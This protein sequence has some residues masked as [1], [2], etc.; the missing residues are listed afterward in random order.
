MSQHKDAMCA[1]RRLKGGL[2]AATAIVS[3]LALAA[4]VAAAELQEIVVTAR[5]RQES[6]LNVPVITSAVTQAQIERQQV[7]DVRDVARLVPALQFGTAPTVNGTIV[8]LRGIGT[9]AIDPSVDQSISL[10]LD[11][12]TFSQGLSY[13]AVMFDVGQV[14]VLRGPQALFYGK[15]SPAGVISVRSADPGQQAEFIGRAGYEFEA[16]EQR[17][18]LIASGPLSDTVGVRLAGLYYNA[19]GFFKNKAIAIPGTGAIAPQ[20]DRDKRYGHVLRAT[21]LWE[22]TDRFAARLKM[23]TVKDRWYFAGIGQ[24]VSCPNGTIGTSVLITGQIYQNLGADD[25]KLDRISRVNSLDPAAFQGIFFNGEPQLRNQQ[26]FGTLNLDYRITPELTLTSLTGYLRARTKAVFNGGTSAAFGTT[27]D[28]QNR[29]NRKE[30]QQEFRLNSDYAGPFNFS[31]GLFYQDGEIFS[32]SNLLTN[33]ALAFGPASIFGPAGFR[34]P[35]VLTN[36]FN[37]ID[38]KTYSAFAQGRFKVTP[39]L[40]IAA[41]A[42]YTDEKRTVDAYNIFGGVRTPIRLAVTEL[43]AKNW[44]PELTVSYKPVDTVT[45]FGSLKQGYKS[46]SFALGQAIVN[47]SNNSF[48]D[49]RVRGGEL[50]LKSRLFDRRLAMDLSTYYYKY[51]GLQVGASEASAAGAAPQSRV[52]NAGAAR[53]YGFEWALSYVPEQIEG[54][55]LDFNGAYTDAKFITLN[56]IPCFG[57]QMI[58]EGCNQVRNP[59]T[60]L[61]VAQDLSGTR[62]PNAPKWSANFGF[63]YERPVGD[64]MTVVIGNNNQYVGKYLYLPALRHIRPDFVAP[65]YFKVNANIALRGPEDRW[66][67]ALIGNNIFNEITAGQCSSTNGQ[68]GSLNPTGGLI[69]GGTTRG[70]AGI[71][72]LTCRVDRGREVWVRFTV[73]PSF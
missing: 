41:G 66:E 26:T 15:S 22:P 4:P 23:N 36:N 51:K 58:S 5:K 68:N 63:T 33:Q 71:D 65:D 12:L 10:N 59:V 8:T 73:R 32:Q 31:G 55:T 34:F 28:V 48:G 21:V 7:K 42:R 60:G 19:D 57:G 52:V 14:E 67:L 69:T 16:R 11:G 25:C 6:I 44:S 45:V 50:G 29:L 9:S 62:M 2:L 70:V 46:G 37:E 40:E 61:F 27:L 24:F 72:E 56:N 20:H 39:E 18:E 35:P 53:T 54:L 47:G 1:A 64:G 3:S 30:F 43:H 38:I 17:Y 13:S 49:E